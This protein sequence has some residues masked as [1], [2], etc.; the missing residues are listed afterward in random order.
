MKT[1]LNRRDWLKRGSLTA[2]GVMAV[3]FLSYG[4]YADQPIVID[5]QGNVPYTPFFKEYLPDIYARLFCYLFGFRELCC[6]D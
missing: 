3:P 1:T 4:A 2:A 6:F 5:A